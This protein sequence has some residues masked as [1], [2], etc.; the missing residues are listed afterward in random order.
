MKKV[1]CS[2]F[3][4][5]GI[6]FLIATATASIAHEIKNEHVGCD[7]GKICLQVITCGEHENQI[8][9][10]PTS[11]GPSNCDPHMHIAPSEKHVPSKK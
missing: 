6:A 7:K 3:I 8:I 5:T 1:V 4:S 11:C 9:C 2:L 10:Y